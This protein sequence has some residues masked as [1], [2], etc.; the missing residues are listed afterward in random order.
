M[1]HV[2][3]GHGRGLTPAMAEN[4]EAARAKRSAMRARVATA[5]AGG[6]TPAMAETDGRG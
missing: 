5:M 2:P 3:K 4:G 6:L 1:S